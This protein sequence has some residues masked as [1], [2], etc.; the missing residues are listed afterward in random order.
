MTTHLGHKS[1]G[2]PVDLY[3]SPHLDDVV[4][5][6]G[7]R[8]AAGRREGRSAVVVSVFAAPIPCDQ[9]PQFARNYHE[10]MGIGSDPFLRQREDREALRLLG[11]QPIH[12]GHLDCIYRTRPD[13]LPAVTHEREIFLFDMAEEEDLL[14]AVSDDLYGPIISVDADRVV[15]PLALGWHRDHVLTRRAAER[16]LGRAG[17]HIDV[18]YFEDV[19]YVIQAPD[20]VMDAARGM[21]S[22]AFPLTAAELDARL[23]AISCYGS[24]RDILWHQGQGLG[25]AICDHVHRVGD[26]IP[27]ERY[28]HHVTS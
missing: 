13:G 25:Q 16:A 23:A 3:I 10:I 8:L 22:E 19:P 11:A 6:C 24:Q 17:Q 12:L 26:G 15:L 1:A 21:R 28:W 9:V 5:S 18:R 14:Q 27:T 4:L 2:K 20:D 7:G